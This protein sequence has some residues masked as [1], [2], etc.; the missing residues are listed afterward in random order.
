M[1]PQPGDCGNERQVTEDLS[2]PCNLNIFK[3]EH[4]QILVLEDITDQLSGKRVYCF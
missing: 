1:G 3:G 4:F 2:D